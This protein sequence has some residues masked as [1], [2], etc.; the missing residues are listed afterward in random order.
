MTAQEVHIDFNE[1]LQNS[2]SFVRRNFEP[3]Q[4]D[5]WINDAVIRYVE[6]NVTPKQE[7]QNLIEVGFQKTKSRYDNVE[8]LIERV[9][10]PLYK[11][12]DDELYAIVPNN[13]FKL[14]D[15]ISSTSYNC[16]G[17]VVTEQSETFYYA[18]VELKDD[19]INDLGSKYS[20]FKIDVDTGSGFTTIGSMTNY[21]TGGLNETKEKFYLIEVVKDIVKRSNITGLEVYW[22]KYGDIVYKPNNFVF[23]RN[24]NIVQIRLTLGNDV[25]SSFI[26][27]TRTK[28]VTD[29][30]NKQ[31][32]LH[33]QSNRLVKSELVNILKNYT[34][35]KTK[36]TSVISELSKGRVIVHRNSTFNIDTL[37]LVYI[38]KP[39]PM[40]IRLERSIDLNPNVH[41]KIVDF[42]IERAAAFINSDILPGVKAV[43]NQNLE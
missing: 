6:N 34:Y 9:E 22:E 19:E 31:R 2:S 15:D 29:N 3:E 25:T 18:T 5:W 12:S 23:V 11:L 36:Y 7:A 1:K 21:Y 42:A 37:N 40:D 20:T 43:V 32:I 4:I 26:P 27:E 24:Q 10:V 17:I 41:E 8:E 33:K 39:I 35:S 38:R 16:N 28:I 14:V 30:S 13:Y